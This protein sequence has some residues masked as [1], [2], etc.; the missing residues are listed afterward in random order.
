M[1]AEEPETGDI[2]GMSTLVD[3]HP[4]HLEVPVGEADLLVR[5][6]AFLLLYQFKVVPLLFAVFA[7]MLPI[8]G[9]NILEAVSIVDIS[10]L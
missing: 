4:D 6:T 3:S 7:G 9:W 8:W 2:G 5:H 1:E 10:I